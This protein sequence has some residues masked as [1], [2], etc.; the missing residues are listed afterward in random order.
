MSA[1]LL[2][3]TSDVAPP[4]VNTRVHNSYIDG[5]LVFSSAS[6]QTGFGFYASSPVTIPVTYNSIAANTMSAS[7]VRVGNSVTVHLRAFSYTVPAGAATFLGT[8]IPTAIRPPVELRVPI[9]IQDNGTVQ[10][11]SIAVSTGGSIVIY[12]TPAGGNF[13]TSGSSGIPFDTHISYSL[14]LP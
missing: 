13:A 10:M 3:D 12:S 14:S 6:G 7:Y 4:N 11:G 8:G 9:I 1:S 5:T 2:T